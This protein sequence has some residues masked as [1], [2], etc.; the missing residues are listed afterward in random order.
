MTSTLIP[1]S[2]PITIQFIPLVHPND[3]FELEQP[4]YRF[5]YLVKIIDPSEPNPN[6][7][8]EFIIV[9]MKHNGTRYRNVE[10]WMTQPEWYYL[11]K[12]PSGVSE[13]F[14]VAEDEICLSQYAH[15]VNPEGEF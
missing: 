8:E 1:A 3:E 5:G 13:E 4:E 7:W 12:R 6:E 15:L 11:L 9:G 2:Q 14:W 10:T